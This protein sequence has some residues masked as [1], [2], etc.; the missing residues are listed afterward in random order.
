MENRGDSGGI[1]VVIGLILVLL[2]VVGGGVGVY[3]VVSRQQ[4][5]L[6][7]QADRALLAE[8]QARREVERAHAEALVKATANDQGTA[9]VQGDSIRTAVESILRAQ[10]DTWNRGDLDAFMEHY[11]KDEALTF[12]SEGKTTRGWASTMTRYKER[13][14]T[15]E[16]MGS[17]KLS[18]LEITPLGDSAALVLGKWNVEREGGPLSGNFFIG[19]SQVR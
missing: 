6:A 7:V 12:S 19:R 14:P 17:L 8:A 1:A 5:L 13:Y 16:K 18:G 10:E 9:T 11:W 3:Y 2:L 15:P 4:M